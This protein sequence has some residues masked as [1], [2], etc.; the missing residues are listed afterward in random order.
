MAFNEVLRL[1]DGLV[2]DKT[3]KH[4][5]NLQ[6]AILR[7]TWDSEK[8]SKIAQ[9]YHCTQRHV[10]NVASKLWQLISEETE[11][12]IQKSN[13][14]AA[15]ERYQISNFSNIFNLGGK[16]YLSHINLCADNTHLWETQPRSPTTQTTNENNTPL[17]QLDLRDAPDITTFYGRS[18]ELTTLQTLILEHRCRLITLSGIS[19]IGKS[20]IIRHLIPEIE[21]DFDCLIWR[22]LRTSPTLD[23][24]LADL[25][26]ILSSPT[27]I[28]LPN[29]INVQ[30]SFLL[31]KL[32]DRRCLI[33]LDDLQYLL[34][35]GEFVGHYRSG[36]ENYGTLFKIIAEL[37]HNSCLIVNSWEP[38]LDLF[39]LTEDDLPVSLF[40]LRGLLKEEACE[41]F[42]QQGLLNEEK[43]QELISFYQGNPR[44]L[45][46]VGKTIKNL[47]AGSV[48]QYLS[49]QPLFLCDELT[50]ILDRHYQRLS[51]LEKQIMSLLGEQ[52]ESISIS[53]LLEKYQFSPPELFQTLLSLERRALIYKITTEV[54]EVSFSVQPVF[55]H[56]ISCYL[57]TAAT[58]RVRS[59]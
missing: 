27:E 37:P 15:M 11:E 53:Q 25:I 22:T 58:T 59:L 46:L 16:H 40:E 57:S 36:Y 42:K 32:R 29:N 48:S 24:T 41:I 9:E 5:D 47:W 23:I 21:S 14:R 44:F 33:I 30:L 20:T 1:V 17:P 43:W 31:E 12:K 54:N 38:P 2:F 52:P 51:E 10:G 3:G 50:Q 13:F 35:R 49:Y 19:G 18:T 8:Y 45:K 28:N 56:Y 26:S 39:S 6:K 7:A 34:S 4:L 55:R